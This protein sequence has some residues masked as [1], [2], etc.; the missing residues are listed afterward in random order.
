MDLLCHPKAQ[1]AALS[2]LP[3][4]IGPAASPTLTHLCFSVHPAGKELVI[5]EGPTQPRAGVLEVLMGLVAVDGLGMARRCLR[6]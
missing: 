3:T 2:V 1:P 5:P 4:L 6:G